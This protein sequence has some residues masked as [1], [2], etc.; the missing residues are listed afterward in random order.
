MKELRDHRTLPRVR[1]KPDAGI[2][3]A[4]KVW[5]E[6]AHA[7]NSGAPRTLQEHLNVYAWR[8]AA[9]VRLYEVGAV[10]ADLATI[11]AMRRFVNTPPGV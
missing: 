3:E 11:E 6:A 4:L 10:K 9:L 8:D 1:Y 2:E 5:S 7:L